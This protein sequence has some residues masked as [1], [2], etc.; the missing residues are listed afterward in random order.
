MANN[1]RNIYDSSPNVDMEIDDD[2]LSDT[3]Q[4]SEVNQQ[5]KRRRT[6]SKSGVSGRS[7]C[8]NHFKP[9]PEKMGIEVK[10]Q[11]PR[12]T[13][14]YTWRGSTSNLVGH[15]KKIHKIVE[16]PKP[17]KKPNT[18]STFEINLPLVKFIITSNQSFDVVNHMAS[19]GFFNKPYQIPKTIHEIEEQINKTYDKLFSKLKQMIQSA[20]SVALAIHVWNIDDKES[21]EKNFMEIT[22]HWLTTDFK[23]HRILLCMTEFDSIDG[24]MTDKYIEQIQKKW[25]LTNY[26][27]LTTDFYAEDELS[28]LSEFSNHK[29]IRNASY[30]LESLLPTCLEQCL[31][32]ENQGI[33]E[34][35]EEI[36]SKIEE[37]QDVIKIL[38]EEEAQEKLSTL[39]NF[40]IGKIIEGKWGSTYFG[41]K[42]IVSMEQQINSLVSSWC[43]DR[44]DNVKSKGDE[45]RALLPDSSQF[46]ILSKLSQIFEPLESVEGI[47][48]D[49][50]YLTINVMHSILAKLVNGIKYRANN[51][52]NDPASSTGNNLEI[53]TIQAIADSI[54][55][56]LNTP[57]YFEIF[58]YANTADVGNVASLLDPRFKLTYSSEKAKEFVQ[59]G[60][61]DFYSGQSR[62]AENPISSEKLPER[63]T[64]LVSDFFS[65]H[66]SADSTSNSN[67]MLDDDDE[68]NPQENSREKASRELKSYLDLPQQQSNIDLYKWWQK[69]QGLYPGLAVLARKYLAVP[70]T[71]YSSRLSKNEHKESLKIL[72]NTYKD[73][74]MI[75]KIVFL[76]HNKNYLDELF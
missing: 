11:V 23:F 36:K 37:I 10:C 74:D 19:T 47:M 50:D 58:F 54:Y 63:Q 26:E 57:N 69:Y 51:I 68:A 55:N 72:L 6:G 75:S 31:N 67:S 43:S 12:C 27:F 66:R 65:D 40:D 2:S 29:Y 16:P 49:C 56:F 64:T 9:Y 32:V 17:V 7:F 45:L 71:S 30:F 15:L 24:T 48:N 25:E 3:S 42:Y 18:N 44:D 28:I 46:K 21:F 52:K 39:T 59:K 8:W 22:C 5:A 13:T 35:V 61:E 4:Q 76:Q 38:K 14:K 20:E 60:C 34:K 1:K 53:N 62:N 73:P 70:A 41:L 33:L